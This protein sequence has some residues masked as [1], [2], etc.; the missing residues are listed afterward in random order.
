[1]YISGLEPACDE[2][3]K[4]SE[5]LSVRPSAPVEKLLDQRI[6]LRT[7]EKI[8]NESKI[9]PAF[10]SRRNFLQLSA[11]VGAAGLLI[12][13][14]NNNQKKGQMNLE[15]KTN[16]ATSADRKTSA[17]GEYAELDGLKMYYEIHGAGQPLLVLNGSF[18]AAS[19]Y[20][21]LADGR[22]MIAADVQGH[23]R[24]ADIDR[25][26]I[27]EQMADDAAALLKHLKIERADMFGYS[28]GGTIGL[29]M[30]I[31]HPDL[32][33]RLAIFGSHYRPIE[34][35][36]SP[37]LIKIWNEIK[38]ETFAPEDIKEPY[39]R[40]S[41]APNWKVLVA[42]IL[43]MEKDFKGFSKEQMK[44]IKAEV[45][46]GAG[47]T[48]D[49]PRKHLA[50]MRDLIPKSQLTIFP[51]TDHVVLM[52]NPDDKKVLSPIKEFLDAKKQ[53]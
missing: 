39:E 3:I 31:R 37:D 10:V 18:M 25:P 38:P 2:K 16:Q 22:Q 6:C 19:V 51:N 26:F 44:A 40:Q 42:K 43:Q 29:A 11:I 9:K 46:I 50:E 7:Q 21:T 20:P 15:A 35:A 33:R 52:K 45:F 5:R 28:M 12:N 1:M 36:W 34:E 14:Q 32:I 13:C 41:P 17:K 30:A 47:D 53:S 24:T 49:I 8:R 48:N 27:F 4:R 23:G